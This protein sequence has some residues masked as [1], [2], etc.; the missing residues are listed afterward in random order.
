MNV[1]KYLYKAQDLLRD[2]IDD[3]SVYEDYIEAIDKAIK[4]YNDPVGAY[5]EE[6]AEDLTEDLKEHPKED[7]QQL[8]EEWASVFGDEVGSEIYYLIDIG[9][10]DE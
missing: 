10:E 1:V 8:A 2:Y 6:I 3:E 4:V 7:R 5:T 9:D